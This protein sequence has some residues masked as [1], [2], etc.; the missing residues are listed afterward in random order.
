MGWL[1]LGRLFALLPG[2]LFVLLSACESATQGETQAEIQAEIQALPVE[3]L[4]SLTMSSEPAQLL[5]DSD[6]NQLLVLSDSR[7]LKQYADFEQ[8]IRQIQ[9]VFAQH[10]D[11][12][13]AFPTL[14]LATT[15][16]ITAGLTAGEFRDAHYSNE[17]FY[18]FAQSYLDPLHDHLLGRELEPQWRYYYH[19]AQSGDTTVALL[20]LIGANA[21]ITVD[22]PQA[23]ADTQGS[24]AYQNGFSSV[25]DYI[26]D[27]LSTINA[28]LLRVY[29]EDL[30]PLYRDVDRWLGD[31]AAVD[32]AVRLSRDTAFAHGIS[33]QIPEE[34]AVTR[35]A[36]DQLFVDRLLLINSL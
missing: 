34:S 26:T 3:P 14:Y 19:A 11:P 33:L 9:S 1:R 21:H 5:S 4:P 2:V 8:R 22:L 13:G 20:A 30:E 7:S 12:R 17:L 31:G 24:I 27:S 10:Q 32:L 28:E 15:E 35:E 18:V 23:I 16:S 29:G 6:I 25:S 36:I